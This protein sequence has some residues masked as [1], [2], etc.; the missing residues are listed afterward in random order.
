MELYVWRILLVDDD[1]DD[2]LITRSLLSA[3]RRDQFI[4]EW[5]SSYDIGREM[6]RCD[7]YDAVIVDY[8]LGVNKGTRLIEEIKQEGC[9]VPMILLTGRGSYEIDLEAM[10]VGAMDYLIKQEISAALLER[11]IRY[12]IERKRG[13]EALE[14]E[15]VRLQTVF[16]NAPSGILLADPEGNVILKNPRLDGLLG[17]EIAGNEKCLSRGSPFQHLDGRPY[18]D[19]EMPISKSVQKGTSDQN[20]NMI[21]RREDGQP[22]YLLVNSSP[23]VSANGTITGAVAVVRDITENKRAEKELRDSE[24]QLRDSAERFRV[25][26]SYVPIT[27]FTMDRDLRYT[28]IY[29][30]SRGITVEEMLGK[31]DDQQ[32]FAED[33]S[34]LMDL[35][36]SV[37]ASGQGIHREIRVKH[38]GDWQTYVV[39]IEPLRDADDCIVGLTGAAMDVTEQRRMEARQI[40][41][42]AQLEVHRRLIE[43]R[44]MERQ[45]I[46]R[47]LHD[48]PIQ[49][50]I[51]LSY[52]LKFISA[53]VY[54][55]EMLQNMHEVE[56]GMQAL[57]NELRSVCNELRPPVLSS[58]GLRIA[59]QAYAEEFRAKNRGLQIHLDI[60]N[61]G[62]KIADGLSLSLYRVYQECLN[63]IV[64]HAS[65]TDVHIR[66]GIEADQ[67]M[68]EIADNGTGFQMP[69]DWTE[70]IHQG[71]FG[72]VGMKE[73][74]GAVGGELQVMT[75]PGEG[76]RVN[77]VVPCA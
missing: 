25:A 67:I 9:R 62:K 37:I 41:N 8:D 76:T 46:A 65:A 53:L 24:A 60:R 56:E 42:A 2:Y 66:M 1:E 5:A 17:K 10:Q 22:T 33:V 13:E 21:L 32:A 39:T 4:L 50:L 71:H 31:R 34:E 26:L 68:L 16:A 7:Q 40:E 70:L 58:F 43:Q 27:V 75:M 57:I 36:R 45:N 55:Q 64:R 11:S 14:M 38:K 6:L 48:G 69:A 12:A 47:N 54:D 19:E 49:S 35:K 73:R 52:S 23:I 61:D 44:E 74:V 59:I 72:L 20:V 18:L 15:R 30:P 28:W 77:V 51:G 63:N 29:Q 3:S